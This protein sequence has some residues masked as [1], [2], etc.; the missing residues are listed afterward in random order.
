MLCLIDTILCRLDAPSCFRCLVSHGSGANK[1]A[2]KLLKNERMRISDNRKR[3][4]SLT[5]TTTTFNN[6]CITLFSPCLS[7]SLSLSLVF[8]PQCI[9]CVILS[10]WVVNHFSRPFLPLIFS[11]WLLLWW[12]SFSSNDLLIFFLSYTSLFHHTNF[13]VA[14]QSAG[15]Q[16]DRQV[17]RWA[18]VDDG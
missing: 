1:W 2:R 12:F 13:A 17:G 3:H 16:T 4:Y 10:V 18:E 6:I 5:T 9:K 8:L 7:L 11:L 14:S 15:K